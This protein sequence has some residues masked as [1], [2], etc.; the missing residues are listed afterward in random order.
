MP[1]NALQNAP[2]VIGVHGIGRLPILV[3]PI[4]QA[5]VA[6]VAK[7]QFCDALAACPYGNVQGCVTS[8]RHKWGKKQCDGQLQLK[9]TDRKTDVQIQTNK[10]TNKTEVLQNIVSGQLL[11]VYVESSLKEKENSKV[12]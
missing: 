5:T 1:I 2:L 7:Q 3:R 10:Q 4:Q 8:L 11:S 6:G 9:K 12:E